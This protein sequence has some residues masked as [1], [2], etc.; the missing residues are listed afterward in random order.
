M[1]SSVDGR[2]LGFDLGKRVAS[3]IT[4]GIAP[5]SDSRDALKFICKEFWLYMFNQQAT[6]LQANKKGVFVIYDS[7]FSPLQTLAR[8]CITTTIRNPKSNSLSLGPLSHP[9]L[10]GAS[11]STETEESP[12]SGRVS[13]PSDMHDAAIMRDADRKLELASG[14]LRGFLAA[15][16]YKCSVDAAIY[17]GLPSCAFT[18]SL[19]SMATD[20]INPSRLLGV[21]GNQ[22][23]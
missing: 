6:R 1:K 18:I 15:V 4:L 7:N 3:R 12:F 2:D 13:V 5:F 17:G 22:G 14:I 20:V 8:L 23:G 10:V 11:P 16:G 9:M 19:S 21:M